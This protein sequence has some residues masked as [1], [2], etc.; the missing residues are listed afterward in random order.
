MLLGLHERCR[1]RCFQVHHQFLTE[2]AEESVRAT[3]NAPG[4]DAFPNGPNGPNA[5]LDLP[6]P[7]HRSRYKMYL[8]SIYDCYYLLRTADYV[9]DLGGTYIDD[10]VRGQ[11][12]TRINRIQLH[13]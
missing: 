1:D 11:N 8:S 7:G 2:N 12:G 4:Q 13:R 9:P 6:S 5:P 10:I 3:A